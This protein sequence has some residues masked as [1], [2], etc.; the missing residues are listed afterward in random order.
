MTLYKLNPCTKPDC[1]RLTTATY[2]CGPCSA[3]DEEGYEIHPDGPLGHTASCNQR[4]RERGPST[5]YQRVAH[6]AK[7]LERPSS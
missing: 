6:R 7:R 2:C 1:D 5:E 3:A 4:Y